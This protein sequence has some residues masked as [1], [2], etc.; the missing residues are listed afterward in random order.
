VQAVIETPAFLASARQEGVS[1]D[2]LDLIKAAIARNPDLGDV[3]EG[4]GGAR[5]ARFAGRGKGKSGGYRVITFFGGA[6]IPVFLLDI[7]GKGSRAN[8]TKAERNELHSILSR[9]P[10]E[11]RERRKESLRRS[12]SGRPSLHK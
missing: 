12:K 9:L 3:I 6:D 11:W 1:E 5:K 8:L 10:Q 4:A 2:E 7:F